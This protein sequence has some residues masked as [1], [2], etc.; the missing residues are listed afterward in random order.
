[1]KYSRSGTGN[2]VCPTYSQ[3]LSGCDGICEGGYACFEGTGECLCGG[4]KCGD[5]ANHCSTGQCM[6][7]DINH[8]CDQ[9][10]SLPTCRQTKNHQADPKA[11][12]KGFLPTGMQC[13]VSCLEHDDRYSVLSIP[14]ERFFLI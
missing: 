8:A 11:F 10:K 14:S 4:K 9:D 5:E 6:C 13:E 3:C 2:Y 7:G 12:E 1:M